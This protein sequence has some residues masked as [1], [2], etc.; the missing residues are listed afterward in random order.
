MRFGFA[1][2]HQEA[3]FLRGILPHARPIK[4][5][6]A[7]VARGAMSSGTRA[8]F[9]VAA[10]TELVAAFTIIWLNWVWASTAF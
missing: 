8:Y 6:R 1:K 5:P 10:S 4:N 7:D 9:L 2:P 3:K